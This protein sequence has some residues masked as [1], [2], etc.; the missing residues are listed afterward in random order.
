MP[1]M[2]CGSGKSSLGEAARPAELGSGRRVG[3]QE[4]CAPAG[5]LW[6]LA[7]AGKEQGACRVSAHLSSLGLTPPLAATWREL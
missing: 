1:K 7:S 6:V 2:P 3:E 4:G 5:G